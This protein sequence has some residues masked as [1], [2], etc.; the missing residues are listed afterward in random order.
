MWKLFCDKCGNEHP[1]EDKEAP[2]VFQVFVPSYADG[3]DGKWDLCETCMADL[4]KYVGVDLH[5]GQQE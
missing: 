3:N 4:E 2:L 5:S 1:P